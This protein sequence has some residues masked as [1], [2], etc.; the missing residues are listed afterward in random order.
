MDLEH[1]VHTTQFYNEH[2]G[3]LNDYEKN[4]EHST[5]Y[6]I[7]KYV[8]SDMYVLELGARYGTV[9]VYLD[10]LLYKPSEQ[11]VCVEA[12]DTVIPSLMKSRDLNEASFNIYNGTISKKELYMVYNGCG[13]ENKTYENP[14]ENL[15]KRKVNTITLDDIQQKYN[16]S[17]D[18]LIAD[19]EGFLLDFILE[20]TTFLDQLKIVIYEE[21]CCSSHPINNSF[22][23]YD[24]ITSI[25]T[26]K[27]FTLVET[28]TDS[29]G[30]HNRCWIHS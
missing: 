30:L 7:K 3:F 24:R 29:I 27:G 25:L 14:P 28:H 11:L 19:C 15:Q 2:N 18:C 21:D 12:D 6:L 16:I 10:K 9:S 4:I 22:I 26:E 23:D 5:R 8:K 1:Y 13:W 20:N 17:F